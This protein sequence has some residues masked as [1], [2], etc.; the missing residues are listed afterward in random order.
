M[1][2]R[3][4]MM[5]CLA[6]ATMSAFVLLLG[7][8]SFAAPGDKDKAKKPAVK[9][10]PP[11][12]V[13]MDH[14]TLAKF[15]DKAIADKLKAE[16]VTTAPLTSDAEFLRRVYLDITGHIPSGDKA[17]AFL[18]DKDPNKR[19]KLIDELLASEDY[20]KHLAD[21]WQALLLPKNSDN[22]RL[23]TAPMAK[24][25]EENFNKN[26]H[27]NTM[28]HDLLTA[29]GPQDKNGAVTFFVANGTVD[30]MTDEVTKVFL[31][32]QL[33]C[34]QCHNHPFTE[35]KQTEYWGM[36]AFF[37]KVQ[38]QN[39]N[40]AAK[41]GNA[42]TVAEVDNVRRG[43]NALPE[44]AKILPPKFLAAETP[45]VSR[46]GPVRPVL[47]DWLTTAQNPFFSKAMANRIWSQ[48]FGR[49]V[50]NPV[51]D[52]HDDNPPS[53]PELLQELANQFAK[54]D[55]DVK[56]LIR[57]ICNSQAYQRTSKLSGKD[58]D[59][60]P[61]LYAKMAVK[62]LTGEH[63]FDS[64]GNVL[65]RQEGRAAGEARKGAMGKGG[66]GGNQRAV[67]VA[68]FGAD[69]TASVTEYQSGIPQAL[70]LMNSPRINTA[71]QA[72]P[73]VRSGSAPE[74][75]IEKLYLSTL[76]R[77]P[78]STEIEKMTAHVK[79]A[80]APAKGYSDILWALLNSSEFTLNH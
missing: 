28:V 42:P 38:A 19:S 11:S 62:V 47:A 76:S 18:D 14:T 63:L 5:R 56:Y 58:S 17:A 74:V 80:D 8:L 61:N 53:H 67:F 51:D 26:Q 36:A 30:K 20:G 55:F 4:K 54:N 13:R 6:I 43:K 48:Y 12:G 64:L 37:M 60:A 21:I 57:A 27:W 75:V 78:T 73:L 35:W 59:P 72:N 40:Q 15:I 46:T 52:M 32:V 9:L 16:G 1:R 79:K 50:V 71:V 23:D 10:P 39:A 31:G 29:S 44:S 7:G 41:A 24:W 77:R 25:L 49:G 2:V 22:R 45:N 33:Q 34:A 68:F 65:G 69:E 70:N 3:S 66:P